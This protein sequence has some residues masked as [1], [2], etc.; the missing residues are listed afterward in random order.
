L[1]TFG[2]IGQVAG[3]ACDFVLTAETL[4][5]SVFD[6][7]TPSLVAFTKEDETED[8]SV[9]SLMETT[10][11]SL[12]DVGFCVGTFDCSDA[13]HAKLCSVTAGHF[14]ALALYLEEPKKN[15]YTKKNYRDAL[16]YL[17]KDNSQETSRD[18]EKF[19]AKALG[20]SRVAIANS[21]SKAES[22]LAA[23]TDQSIP[24][25]VLLSTKSQS[26]LLWRSI[27]FHFRDRL[28]F[29][30]VKTNAEWVEDSNLLTNQ[31]GQFSAPGVLLRSTSL[32]TTASYSGDLKNYAD[33]L[34]WLSPY[35]LP[36]KDSESKA[37]EESEKDSKKSDSKSLKSISSNEFVD[38]L[39]DT[40]REDSV[41]VVAVMPWQDGGRDEVDM[42]AL[43][44]KC[45][46]SV[47]C[48]EFSC[49]E[50]SG[51][52]DESV[53]RFCPGNSGGSIPSEP[54][55]LLVPY[56]ASGRTQLLATPSKS[57]IKTAS[58]VFSTED[59]NSA[60][61]KAHDSFPDSL[62]PIID[63]TQVENFL[64]ACVQD[65]VFGILVVSSS[66]RSS[67][68]GMLRHV[69]ATHKDIAKI[70]YLQNP[71]P[72]AL[73]KFGLADLPLPTAMA[74]IQPPEGNQFQVMV[75]D[76]NH[77]GSMNFRSLSSFIF[78]VVEGA[79]GV[80]ERYIKKMQAKQANQGKETGGTASASSEPLV[81]THV[82]SQEGWEERCG[83][84][85]KGICV[86]GFVGAPEL[87]TGEY[88]GNSI[89]IF[90]NFMNSLS[91]HMRAS[92]HFVWIDIACQSKLAENFDL[93]PDVT[94]ALVMYSPLKK[95]YANYVGNFKLESL[96]ALASGMLNSKV[97]TFP[98]RGDEIVYDDNI[99]CI[100]DNMEGIG[101]EDSGDM[102]DFL[103]EIKREEEELAE[104]RRL[105]LEEEKRLAEEKAKE[106]EKK[107]KKK[108]KKKK[109]TKK[110][111]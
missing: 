66:S 61:K 58:G 44:K 93:T 35:A 51:A 76:V 6:T 38:I 42:S 3:N 79:P 7:N 12:G 71:S 50:K 82:T 83:E 107:T 55:L 13:K 48:V 14:P 96:K 2:V 21:E 39:T 20:S 63:E 95:R 28:Q 105:E 87:S 74:M 36:L 80:K 18:I 16:P 57:I 45:Y 100:P 65:D 52:L 85:F 110:E 22:M 103:A 73:Q 19:V 26:N 91:H 70:A 88:D 72:Q 1:A 106:A 108:K 98:V 86:V 49:P 15:P 30:Q 90:E 89:A 27:A 34:E 31:L 11:A 102:D 24:Q 68:P 104:A 62:A 60:A 75:Y 47:V 40:S 59:L 111:L 78:N 32:E 4:Q 5:T 69:A 33:I 92:F 23:D 37:E 77:F 25:V 56:T 99:N 109:K 43:Q 94:P 54:Y 10:A 84:S 53:A 17:P 41:Y 67:A 64:G 9:G 46:G 8:N 81:L 101:S 97:R 29:V